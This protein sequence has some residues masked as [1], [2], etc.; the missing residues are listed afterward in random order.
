MERK[1]NRLLSGLGPLD[2]VAPVSRNVKMIAGSE[3][4]WIFVTLKKQGCASRQER[5]PFILVLVIPLSR[6]RCLAC[7][8]DALKIQ[9]FR[10]QQGF[11]NLV[12]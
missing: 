1:P 3:N 4:V 8:D 6:R 9:R 12:A 2:P 11:E 5:Y 7:G 10:L